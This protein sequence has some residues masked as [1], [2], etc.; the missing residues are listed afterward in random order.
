MS[1]DEVLGGP[2]DIKWAH[3]GARFHILQVRPITSLGPPWSA[4]ASL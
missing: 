3:D 2:Q 1:I 4:D